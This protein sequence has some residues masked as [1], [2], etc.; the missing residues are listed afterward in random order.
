KLRKAERN[1]ESIE[2]H[3][4]EAE[5][6][7]S[8]QEQYEQLS[9]QLHRLEGNIEGY[10]KSR[11]QSA[12]GQCPLLKETC[13]NIKQRGIVSL[14]SYFDGLLSA[15]HAEVQRL[16]QQQTT[17]SERMG[18]IKKYTDALNKIG[19]YIDRRDTLAEQLQ[20]YAIEITRLE[21]DVAN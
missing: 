14:E 21:R 5:E 8:L 16:R 2:E 20:R 3:R 12:G 1:V 4:Q 9:V 6:M 19:Q 13:L 11:T 15:E 10:V 17:I 7:S 18:Q